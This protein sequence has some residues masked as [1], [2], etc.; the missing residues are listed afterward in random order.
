MVKF[1]IIFLFCFNLYSTEQDSVVRIRY[2]RMQD[3]VTIT[4]HGTAFSI[5]LPNLDKNSHY[6]LTAAHNTLDGNKQPYTKLM[7]ENKNSWLPCTVVTWN[8]DLDICLL[9]TDVDIPPLKLGNKESTV[10]DTIYL[11]GSKR[12]KPIEKF[13]GI[14]K[15]KFERGS[16]RFKAEIIF[17]H[18]DSGGPIINEQNLVIGIAVAGLPKDN[19]L[20]KNICLFVPLVGIQAFLE[21]ILDKK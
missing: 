21:C 16:A 9:K 6:L 2:E 10:N 7:I 8:E 1:L 13:P 18:G 4:G 3:D 12:G 20:D 14:V 15:Q 5:D 19:D 17:D 11:F